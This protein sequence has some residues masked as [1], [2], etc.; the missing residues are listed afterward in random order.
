[1][2]Y[3][4][5]VLMIACGCV[6]LLISV[7]PVH[8]IYKTDSNLGWLVLRSLVVFFVF[9]YFGVFYY[10][11]QKITI[12][13]A[14]VIVSAIMMGGGFFVFLVTRLSLKSM[15]KLNQLAAQERSNLLHDPLTGLANRAYLMQT[16]QAHIASEEHFGLLILDLNQFKQINDALGHYFGD[17]LLCQVGLKISQ[18]L[19]NTCTLYR[20]GGDEFAILSAASISENLG[21]IDSRPVSKIDDIAQLIHST[22]DKNF[23]IENY[24]FSVS[25]SIG[26]TDF[27]ELGHSAD[28]LF[29]QANLALYES[30]KNT[31]PFTHYSS[32]FETSAADNLN[33]ATRLKQAIALEEFE[34]WYQPIIDLSDGSV[35]GAE[36]LI[37]WPQ[38]DG[39]Y[40]APD[41]FIKIAE[42]S[43]LITKITQWVMN[44]VKDDIQ[45]FNQSNLS[46]CVHLNLSV[47]DLQSP[48]LVDSINSIFS[49]WDWT[50]HALMLEVTESA[51][52]TDVTRVKTTMAQIANTGLAFSIDD[53]GTGYSSLALLRDLPVNQIKIDRSFVSNILKSEDDLAIVKSTIYLAKN[54]GCNIVAEGVEDA[55]TGQLLKS[56]GCDHA[57]GYY[58]SKPLKIESFIE[59]AKSHRTVTQ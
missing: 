40:I 15:V 45:L 52:M 34:L 55:Q 33:I 11:V 58:Y 38:S 10:F 22:M 24:E 56:L 6:F 17:V 50:N 37:R 13:T 16:M 46:L 44:I 31:S 43:L 25:A 47:K 26:G 14:D 51:M 18:A 21:Q 42:Q 39:S 7:R 23:E 9:G 4:F 27:P 54:L 48:H 8:H 2:L 12:N 59:F 32:A 36:A 19:P 3:L 57:Q 53:F 28:I 30:K 49:Q 1:M 20:S 41:K 5:S 35:N 29:G